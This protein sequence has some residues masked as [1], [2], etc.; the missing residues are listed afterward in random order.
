MKEWGGIQES[1]QATE[2]VACLP[3]TAALASFFLDEPCEWELF[4]C[5]RRQIMVLVLAEMS[6]TRC[7]PPCIHEPWPSLPT[8]KV[9][10]LRQ[11]TT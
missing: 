4:W 7:S 2:G 6:Q 10:I 1:G 3:L 5:C 9:A 8:A 11:S